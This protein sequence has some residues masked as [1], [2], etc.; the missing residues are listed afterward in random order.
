MAMP[1]FGKMIGPLPLGAWL[2][3]SGGGLGFMLYQRRQSSAVIMPAG[4]SVMDEL[5][6]GGDSNI[7]TGV[8]GSWVDVT[9]PPSVGIDPTPINN[10]EWGRS[11]VNWLIAQGYS[12]MNADTA[13]RKYLVGE[14]L[15]PQE[16][17]LA[18]L[19]L[20]HLHA[21]PETLPPSQ[22]KPPAI[23]SGPYIPVP[24]VPRNPGPKA[25]I[26]K[27]PIPKS[28][29]KPKPRKK[30]PPKKTP[31][32][33]PRARYYTVRPGDSLSKIAQKYYHK[34]DW[35]RIYNANKRKIH[36]PN[37]IIPGTRLLIP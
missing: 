27:K 2:A 24:R 30:V 18:G 4:G 25:P 32:P 17:V 7:G 11:A 3:V 1:D 26:P 29:P 36:N 9:P 15:S 10:E 12:P 6:A 23:P 31:A 33:K 16:F 21:P 37:L 28:H 34:P 13:I 8:N 14:K 5:P 35:Q 19:A 22:E 20:G